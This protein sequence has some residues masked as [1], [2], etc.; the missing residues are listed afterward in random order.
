MLITKPKIYIIGSSGHAKVLKSLIA[1]SCEFEFGGFILD[2]VSTL[3]QTNSVVS[4]QEFLS[5][6]VGHSAHV[7]LGIGDRASS[8]SLLVNRFRAINC[9]FPKI[10]H[11]SCNVDTTSAIAEGTV[12]LPLSSIKAS[13]VIGQFCIINNNSTI[14][15][16]SEL[17]D[18]VHLSLGAVICGNCKIGQHTLI[19]ANATILPGLTVG[20][21]CT[22]GA[23]SVLT[24]NVPDN[25]T[26]AGNPAR[27]IIS[28]WY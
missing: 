1:D 21:N 18:F 16:D 7:L 24:K 10:L 19:G 5:A 27:K 23:G 2:D 28:K 4:E 20:K 22:V 25:E 12:V 26:W 11:S 9:V 17:E 14:G 15:H 6:N 13:S 3:L 8:I